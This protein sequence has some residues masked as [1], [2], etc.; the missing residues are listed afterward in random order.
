MK[1]NN[2]S[3]MFLAL[4]LSLVTA[5][6]LATTPNSGSFNAGGWGG[7]AN[8]GASSVSSGG[9][10]SETATSQNG[11]A[12]SANANNGGGSAYAGG[13]VGYDGVDAWSGVDS[14]SQGGSLSF[15]GGNYTSNATGGNG[16]D[17]SSYASGQWVTGGFGGY[18][19]WGH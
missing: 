2:L 19:G 4:I 1:L 13:S 10:M 17:V 9:S 11:Y 15:G 3:K 8:G 14:F 12:Y 18:A 5:A 6:A 7:Y 16:T